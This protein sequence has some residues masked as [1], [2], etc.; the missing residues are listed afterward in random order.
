MTLKWVAEHK[1]KSESHNK[2]LLCSLCCLYTSTCKNYTAWH[3][4]KGKAVHMHTTMVHNGMKMNGQL[5]APA[6]LPSGKETPVP[7]E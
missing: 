3:K 2:K 1:N 7:I 4:G 5:H 6:T